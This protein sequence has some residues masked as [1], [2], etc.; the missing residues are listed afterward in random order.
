[1]VILQIA[2]GIENSTGMLQREFMGDQQMLLTDK[3]KTVEQNPLSSL[4]RTEKTN[5]PVGNLYRGGT[6]KLYE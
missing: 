5:L 1:M 6:E 2:H 4:R 3:D